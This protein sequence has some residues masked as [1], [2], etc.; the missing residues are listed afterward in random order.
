MVSGKNRLSKMEDNEKIP[1]CVTCNYAHACSGESNILDIC[2]KRADNSKWY[3]ADIKQEKPYYRLSRPA[4]PLAFHVKSF[5]TTINNLN[6]IGNYTLELCIGL[7]SG[8][9]Q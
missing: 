6:P 4:L 3:A 9:S 1:K 8:L 7:P 2:K 5:S